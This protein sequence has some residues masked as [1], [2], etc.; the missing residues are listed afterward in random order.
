MNN[1]RK[2]AFITEPRKH[3]ALKFVLENFMSILPEEW[4]F[5]I[6]HGTDNLD[7]IKSIID[8][9]Y[10]VSKVSSKNRIRFNNLNVQNLQHEDE[11]FLS[12]T[13]KFWDELEGD[14]LLKFECDTIL[15]PN[16]EYKVSDFEKHDFIGG[17]WGSQLYQPLDDL[18]PKSKPGG[19]Y[20]APYNGPQALPMNGALSLRKS[21]VMIDIIRNHLDEYTTSGKPYA[22]DYFFSE[23]VTK[24]TTRDVLNF[25][26][27]N[28]YVRPLD[29]KAPFGLHKPWGLNPAKGQGKYYN[30]IKKVCKEVEELERLNGL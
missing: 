25:S 16:S 14:L 24:P 1:I 6:N 23:Y 9:S 17:Y 27:D 28:G 13:E 2:V 18:Y 3:R 11:S 8:N 5:V 26:I 19:A 30:E 4:D 10:I 29:G 7:Y 20:S 21:G 12:K 22:D 15:C